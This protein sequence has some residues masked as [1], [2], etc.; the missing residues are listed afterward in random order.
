MECKRCKHVCIKKGKRNDQQ[1]YRCTCCRLYQKVNYLYRKCNKEDLYNIE[2]LHVLGMSISS[3]SAYLFIPKTTV[4]R[5]ISLLASKKQKPI[6][7][8][9]GQTYEIDEMQTYIKKNCTENYLYIVYAINRATRLVVDLAVGKRNTC[10]IEKVVNSVLKLNPKRVFTDK[11]NIYP[12]LIP[13]KIHRTSNHL[14][15]TI[16][17]MNLSLRTHLKRLSRK[18]ICYSKSA[19]IL[20]DALKLYLIR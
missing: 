17:R 14:I 20:E 1:Y 6:L 16:E 18:T 19:D 9:T 8:E 7:N 13:A 15:N 4:Q 12:K 3:I 11:L 2:R 5:K 10:T